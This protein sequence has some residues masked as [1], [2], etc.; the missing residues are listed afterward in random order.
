M[1][2]PAGRCP[3][4]GEPVSQFAAGCA[5]CGFDLEAHRERLAER[6]AS[7]PTAVAAARLPGWLRRAPSADVHV[8]RLIFAIA[9]TLFAPFVGLFLAAWFAYHADQDGRDGIRNAQI[10]VCGFAFAMLYFV[11]FSIW[12]LMLS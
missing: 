8:T 3:H 7:A 5:I 9:V 2:R 10:A 6:R 11:P 4:C 12:G 1:R